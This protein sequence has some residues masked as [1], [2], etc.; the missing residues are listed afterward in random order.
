[1]DSKMKL[2][3]LYLP[4]LAALI[5][6]L[7]SFCSSSSVQNNG[8]YEY[9]YEQDNGDTADGDED[10]ESGMEDESDINVIVDGDAPEYGAGEEE[11]D[12]N[13]HFLPPL[14]IANIAGV[15]GRNIRIVWVPTTAECEITIER[16]SGSGD[17]FETV[18]IKDGKHGRFLDLALKP[19]TWYRYKLTACNSEG[20]SPVFESIPIKTKKSIAPNFTVNVNKDKAQ[21]NIVLFGISTAAYDYTAD[22]RMVAVDRSGK[23]I[24]E[25]HTLSRGAVTEIQPR[26]DH[27]LSIC[28]YTNYTHI[29][30]D[31]SEL[32]HYADEML[33]HDIDPLEDGRVIALFFDQF[34]DTGFEILGD[35]IV[36][37]DEVNQKVDWRWY[38]KD[39]VSLDDRNTLDIATS[40]FGLGQDWTHSN[41]IHFD[42]ERGKIRLNVRNLNRIYQ[43]DYPSGDVDWIMGDGGDFGEGL[44]SHAHDPNYLADNRFILFDNGLY[45]PG[46]VLLY[47]RVIEIEFDAEKKTAEIVWEYR[48]TPDFYSNAY[49]SV[50]EMDNGNILINDGMSGRVFEVTR[51]KEIVWEMTLSGESIYKAETVPLEFFKEW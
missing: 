3:K 19:E 38:T 5:A 41:S 10:F 32:Y 35:G 47:S 13:I 51:E 23:V 29:D 26:E 16:V 9:N 27:T 49:G 30:L 17:E 36:I 34:Y 44:W 37:L 21:D 1:M 18:A 40:P 50:K 4:L 45:R 46:T 39:H 11:Y 20:C 43:I 25:Y 24:W 42:E 28:T 12:P 22:G 8:D 48:E 31:S 33:H 2:H 14:E 6:I 7:C 15:S